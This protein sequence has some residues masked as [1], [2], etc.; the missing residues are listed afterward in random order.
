MGCVSGVPSWLFHLPASAPQPRST[1]R[2]ILRASSNANSTRREDKEVN[3]VV[4]QSHYFPPPSP[5]LYLCYFLSFLCKRK[6][7]SVYN[8]KNKKKTK[9]PSG[10]EEKLCWQS[11]EQMDQL[12]YCTVWNRLQCNWCQC[13]PTSAVLGSDSQLTLRREHWRWETIWRQLSR[14]KASVC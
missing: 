5:L 4:S 13:Q 2:S 11:L 8:Y 3:P 6:L 7:K 10:F 1:K 12:L 9:K 14:E